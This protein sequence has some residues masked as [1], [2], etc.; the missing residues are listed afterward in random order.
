MTLEA[1][2][3]APE[4]AAENQDG[5]VVR[6]NVE[7]PTVVFFYPKDETPG[8]TTEARQFQTE[9]D[10]YREAGVELYGVS[11]DD[12]ESHRAFREAE[13]LKFDLLADPNEEAVDAFDVETSQGAAARTTV[14]LVDGEVWRV[15]ENVDPD[16]HAREVLSDLLDAGVASLE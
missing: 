8:C 6:P 5:T 12:A 2:D 15:Y 11:T 1:G 4:V 16:G 10:V 3:A 13:G 9:L 7:G 14:V